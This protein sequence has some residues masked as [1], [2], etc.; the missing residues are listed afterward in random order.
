MIGDQSHIWDTFRRFIY[1]FAS[2]LGGTWCL[3]RNLPL[4]GNRPLGAEPAAWRRT[5]THPYKCWGWFRAEVIAPPRP[6]SNTTLTWIHLWTFSSESKPIHFPPLCYA[7]YHSHLRF[8]L[9]LHVFS[10]SLFAAQ[11]SH[12]SC[13]CAALTSG[14]NHLLLL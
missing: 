3:N 6:R 13:F 11:S 14:E 4:E 10:L 5:G 2:L 8:L 12:S 7:S 9:H 1:L